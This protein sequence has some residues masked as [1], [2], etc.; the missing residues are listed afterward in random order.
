MDRV[1]GEVSSGKRCR[2]WTPSETGAPSINSQEGSQ[3]PHGAAIGLNVYYSQWHV[4]SHARACNASAPCMHADPTCP[5]VHMQQMHGT[6]EYKVQKRVIK[7][8]QTVVTP[9]TKSFGSEP[10]ILSYQQMCKRACYSGS[11]LR[12][13]QGRVPAVLTS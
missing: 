13:K 3:A 1:C 5:Q 10:W 4:R 6:N 7:Q 2:V 9:C 11:Q 12:T 8:A